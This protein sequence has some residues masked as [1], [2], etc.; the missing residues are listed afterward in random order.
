MCLHLANSWASDVARR[1]WKSTGQRRAAHCGRHVPQSLP[2]Q[3]GLGVLE[4]LGAITLTRN[5]ANACF[6][7]WG[8]QLWSAISLGE[9]TILLWSKHVLFPLSASLFK[10]KLR[11]YILLFTVTEKGLKGPMKIICLNTLSVTSKVCIRMNLCGTAVLKLGTNVK[12]D[13]WCFK[14]RN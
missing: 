7:C 11:K 14:K 1:P 6:F 13:V 5:W 12:R 3:I 8:T 2:D 10:D 4:L 9:P